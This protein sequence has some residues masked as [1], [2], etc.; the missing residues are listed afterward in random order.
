MRVAAR[1]M[2]INVNLNLSC[3]L[4]NLKGVGASKRE[5]EKL[6]LLVFACFVEWADWVLGSAES[7]R[8]AEGELL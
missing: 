5:Y 3:I 8:E 6:A 1:S 4:F 7:E 2:C